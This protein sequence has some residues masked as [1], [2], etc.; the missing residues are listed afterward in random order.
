MPHSAP[1]ARMEPDD[2]ALWAQA[3][4]GDEDAFG[5]LFK[6]HASVIYNYCFRR[7]ADWAIAED[8]LSIVFLEAWKQ[9]AKQLPPGMVLPWLYGVATNVVRNHHRSA[10]RYAS[11]LS[12]VPPA[13]P[14]PDFATLA[15]E[16]LDDERQMEQALAL[17]SRL[18]RHERDVFVLCAWSDLTYEEAAVAL[19]IPIGTVRSRLSSAR[20]RL[21]EL[22]PGI[23]S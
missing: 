8:M 23:R 2:S 18:P 4:K 7:T 12:R 16:R 5:L 22:K 13:Q 17:V 3:S 21:R 14:Q 11:A 9:R 1:D 6:R 20:K 10:R 15:N 19:S